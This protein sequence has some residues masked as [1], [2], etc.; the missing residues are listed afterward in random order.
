MKVRIPDPL[1]SYTGRAKVV[2]AE[3]GTVD[4][5]LRDLD[6]QFPGLRFRMVDEQDRIRKHMKVF[7]NDESVRDLDTP[8]TEGDELTI[9]QALSGG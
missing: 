2:E 4:A 1:R 3:G 7:V 5:V 9:M 8:L 6:R